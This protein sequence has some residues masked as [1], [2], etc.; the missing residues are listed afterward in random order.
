MDEIDGDCYTQVFSFSSDQ[1]CVAD[2]CMPMS[3]KKESSR[4]K[5][6]AVTLQC[7]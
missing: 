6:F 7:V 4:K 2:A 1:G 3:T 5:K